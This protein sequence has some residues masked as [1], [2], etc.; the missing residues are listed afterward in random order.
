MQ[1]FSGNLK[2]ALCFSITFFLS[3]ALHALFIAKHAQVH[4][5]YCQRQAGDH[6]EEVAQFLHATVCIFDVCN[7]HVFGTFGRHILPICIQLAYSLSKTC[8]QS[9]RSV[10]VEASV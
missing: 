4:A 6:Q 1:H 8:L 7:M 10:W 5:P 9:P 3:I 2:R